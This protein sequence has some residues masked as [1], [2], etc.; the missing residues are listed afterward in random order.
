MFHMEAVPQTLLEYVTEDGVNPFQEWMQ[1]IHDFVS[2][3]RIRV[4]L[5]RL[6]LGNFGDSK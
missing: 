5:N 3:A 6:R 2:R 4:R 1:N